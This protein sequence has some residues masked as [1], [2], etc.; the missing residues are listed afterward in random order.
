MIEPEHQSFKAGQSLQA[1]QSLE[2]EHPV[3]A[4]R[5]LREEAERQIRSWSSE[6]EKA[7]HI[8]PE[9]ASAQVASVIHP[10][11]TVSRE[12]G[13]GGSAV[14]KRVAELLDLATIDR[15]LLDYLAEQYRLPRDMLEV[16]DERTCNWLVEVLSI[17]LSHRMVSETDYLMLLG[18][19]VLMS[20][21][22]SSVIFAGRGVQLI[23]PREKTLAVR[24]VAPLERR[25]ECIMAQNQL[26]RYEA[27][28]HVARRDAGRRE[29][30]R[31]HFHQEPSDPHLYDLVINTE[32][33]DTEAA[34]EMIVNLWHR[35]FASPCRAEEFVH[36]N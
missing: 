13:A 12:A 19:F 33:V 31:R 35:R 10:C 7:K 36:G 21:R 24:I 20:A 26:S 17:W 4:E 25:I 28:R 15:E 16:C 18:Q 8:R 23:L 29:F 30:V 3:K 9:L 32:I 14:I 1:G 34:A 27:Q 22:K 2:A 5:Q 11:L 6:L